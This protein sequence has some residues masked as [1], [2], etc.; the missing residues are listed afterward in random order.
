MEVCLRFFRLDVAILVVKTELAQR[1]PFSWPAPQAPLLSPN[2]LQRI[3]RQVLHAEAVVYGLQLHFCW[4][5]ILHKEGGRSYLYTVVNE[6]FESGP[7]DQNVKFNRVIRILLPCREFVREKRVT[8]AVEQRR[9]T[10]V[11]IPV[12]ILN[13]RVCRGCQQKS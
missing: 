10:I 5:A 11:M 1:E 7:V 3:R 6:H 9:R 2:A 8:E 4:G 13:S 12:L